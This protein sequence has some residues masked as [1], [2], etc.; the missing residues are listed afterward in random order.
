[1]VKMV[2]LVVRKEGW[3]HEEFVDRWLGEHAELAKQLPGLVKY[4]TTVA[5]DPERAGYDGIVEF[6]FED[7]TALKEAFDSE[8]GMEVMADA[9][10]FVD[11]EQ[12]PTVIGEET[13]QL[14]DLE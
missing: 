3:S 13:V 7:S 10:E 8:V 1:M 11:T 6:Y 2:D 12:G 5:A 14:D 9:A 4:A